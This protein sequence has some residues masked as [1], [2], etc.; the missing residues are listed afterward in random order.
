MTSRQLD[1]VTVQTT[2]SFP[3]E[4]ETRIPSSDAALFQGMTIFSFAEHV[5][6]EAAAILACFRSG[7]IP[8]PDDAQAA[9]S[10][11]KCNG[12]MFA[13]NSRHNRFG[14]E[15]RCLKSRKFIPAKRIYSDR[16]PKRKA[17]C[18]GYVSPT[19]N[20]FFERVTMST[21]QV[22][23]LAFAWV[24]DLNVTFS[25]QHTGVCSHTAVNYYCLFRQV[26]EIIVSNLPQHIGGPGL[27][28]EVDE[29]FTL[30]RK[31]ERDGRTT[32]YTAV[33]FGAYCRET[34]ECMYW[35]VDNKSRDILWSHMR[36]YIAPGSI[37][38]SDCAPEYRGCT[39]LGY[40]AHLTVNHSARG[41]GRFV[42]PSDPEAHTQNIKVRKRYLK[43]RVR[44]FRT[45]KAIQQYL[46]EYI[47]RSRV[48]SAVATP[49]ER[50]N[51]FL[52]DIRRVYPG[53]GRTGLGLC[54][55]KIDTSS[56]TEY[57]Q[58]SMPTEEPASSAEDH[59]VVVHEQVQDSSIQPFAISMQDLDDAGPSCIFASSC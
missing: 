4:V 34:K 40:S 16:R 12:P 1:N 30:R 13:R 35:K 23:S 44:S 56:T 18:T 48:L 3:P 26:A 55:I 59:V 42:N 36:H 53:P 46:C 17:V 37:I 38:V 5:P 33:Y 54:P 15:Y 11:P 24:C 2:L 51:K 21:K 20:T 25:S 7:L 41:R 14:F 28:V 47:Y 22:L 39:S 58:D 29:T 43:K 8:D 57:L 10:C 49:W 19:L 31:Y 45:D 6:D 52:S 32:E 27:H 9:P 50:F